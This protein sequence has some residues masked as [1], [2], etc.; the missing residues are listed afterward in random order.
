MLQPPTEEHNLSN[1]GIYARISEDPKDQRAG[2]QRQ[3]E[4]ALKVADLRGWSVVEEYIDNDLSAYK[5]A[6]V[7]PSF[8]LMLRDLQAGKLDGIVAYDLD[9][10]V[11]QPRDLERAIDIYEER[12]GLVFATVQGDINLQSADGRTMA[13]VMV[14]FANKSSADTGRR[15]ARAHLETALSG[16]PVG[17]FRPFGWKA[18]KTELHPVEAAAVKSAVDRILAGASLRTIVREW[19]DAEITTTA[20][21]PWKQAT[22]RQYLKNPRLVGL[23]T[24]QREVLKDEQGKPV[25]GLWE[26]MLTT[27]QWDRLA[28]LMTRPEARSRVPRK[29]DRHYLLTGT[30]RCGICSSPM[31]GNRYAEGRHYY[32]CDGVVGVKHTCTVSGIGTDALVGKL[33]LAHVA[34]EELKGSTSSVWE[35]DVRIAEL[36]GQIDSIMGAFLAGTISGDVAFPRVQALEGELGDMR[37]GRSEWLLATTGPAIRRITPKTWEAMDTDQQRA[38]VEKFLSAVLIRP[39]KRR[40]NTLDQE[41]VVPVWREAGGERAPLALAR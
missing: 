22:L 14:A 13:R 17:G 24:H 33:L 25:K 36:Q 32:T 40:G 11:R 41:R 39:A 28:L 7:R 1:V 21:G 19:N 8:E 15:V 34:G 37:N 31:Y 26:P 20:G 30:I 27:G 10:F 23:R 18:N 5:R 3:R 2:V 12:K 6:V 35:G 38:I 9:R 29:G 4:D 16:K